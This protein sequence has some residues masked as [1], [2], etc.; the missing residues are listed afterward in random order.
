MK[1]ILDVQKYWD[2]RPCN[3]RRS[4]AA[5]GSQQFF[6]DTE[7]NKYFVEPHIPEFAEFEK[8]TD[9]KVL[10]IG[11]GIGIDTANFVRFGADVT[12]IDLSQKS[13]DIA[14]QRIHSLP[15]ALHDAHLPKFR[16]GKACFWQANAEDFVLPVPRGHF[17]L[18]YAFGSIHH[19]PHPEDILDNARYFLKPGGTLKIMVYNKYSWKAL[20]IL[21]KYGHGK[22]WRFR[23]LIAKYS[24]AQ[25]GCPITHVFS[26]RELRAMLERNGFVVRKTYKDHIFPYDIEAYKQYRYERTWYWKLVPAPMFRWLEKHFGWHLMCEATV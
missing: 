10:E 6:E 4:P 1:T 19:S 24:E 13:L 22:F 15:W 20:W 5:V 7:R 23:E 12:A 26:P 14:D 11:C 3:I 25:T 18:V 9:K 16:S 21:L 2:S 17:D 8:W